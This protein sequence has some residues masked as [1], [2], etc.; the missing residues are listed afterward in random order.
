MTD[1]S[2]VDQEPTEM[3]SDLKQKIAVRMDNVLNRIILILSILAGLELIATL[4]LYQRKT[5][6]IVI[7]GALLATM[8][9]AK[10]LIRR[11]HVRL[12]GALT[13]SGT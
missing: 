10:L 1:P 13:V 11:G 12:S 9:I 3:N 5:A 8:I 4:F 7:I 6:S 2:G